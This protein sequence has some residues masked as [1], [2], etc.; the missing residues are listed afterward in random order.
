VA[1]GILER[2]NPRL[3]RGRLNSP[4]ILVVCRAFPRV[5]RVIRA[6][7]YTNQPRA[8]SPRRLRWRER[9]HGRGRRNPRLARGQRNPR[10]GRGRLN[11]PAILAVGHAFPRIGP[12]DPRAILC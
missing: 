9:T 8:S 7:F 1:T 5:G 6:R 10:L 2:R 12:G 4:A 11:P 3:T